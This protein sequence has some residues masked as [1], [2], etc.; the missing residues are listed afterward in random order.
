MTLEE[1]NESVF[2]NKIVEIKLLQKDGSYDILSK[3]NDDIY[4]LSDYYDWTVDSI[5]P[6]VYI[7]SEDED[8]VKT[9]CGIRLVLVK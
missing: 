2:I 9:T 1:L 3:R 4:Y 5:E 6:F 7:K 8:V